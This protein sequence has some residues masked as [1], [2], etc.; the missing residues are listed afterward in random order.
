VS[1]RRARRRLAPHEADAALDRLE[2]TRTE[3]GFDRCD[4]V[5]EAI[6]E[7]L[8]VKRKVLTAYAGRVRED[9][10]LCTN[11]SSLSV[12]AIAEGVPNP[13]R[14]VGLH[15]FNPVEKMPLVEVVRGER[16][17]PDVLRRAV[18][19]ALD[20]GK[21]PVVCEDAPG[22]VVNRLL[23]PYLDEAMRLFE[24]G[25][26]PAELDR[27]A[28]EFGLPMGPFTLLDE[29]GLDIAAHTANSLE[30]AF[31]ARMTPSGVLR[32]LLD[33][34]ELGRK[35]G[36]GVFD[37]RTKPKRKDDPKPQNKRLARPKGAPVVSTLPDDERLDRMLLPMVNEAARLLADGV[38]ANARQLDLATVYGM[39]FPP[40]HGGVLAWA[41]REGLTSVVDRMQ[42]L[43]RSPEVAHRPGG[44]ERFEPCEALV[45]RARAGEPFRDDLAR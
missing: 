4:L 11:T 12:D 1:K 24:T 2:L 43:A 5:V 16:T 19:L 6:A 15:F 25:S 38:V 20:L 39:G 33:A 13:E 7:V 31:G 10:V 14:V 23:A 3:L 36:R 42:R 37:H 9:A 28:T 17:A 8:D 21:T 40:F 44:R 34:G 27:L 45:E 32:P 22:F 29:V 30:Q 26:S 41:D 35:S 18:Q